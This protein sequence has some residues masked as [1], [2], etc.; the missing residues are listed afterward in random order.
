MDIKKN[1]WLKR[2]IA[3]YEICNSSWSLIEKIHLQ[4]NSITES[5]F[6][7]QKVGIY[8]KKN[9]TKPEALCSFRSSREAV[10]HI[11]VSRRMDALALQIPPHVSLSSLSKAVKLCKLLLLEA[12]Q[13][14]GWEEA[15]LGVL[16]VEFS[17]SVVSPGDVL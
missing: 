7:S 12:F 4:R 6:E 17:V 3:Y 14:R 5:N 15:S 13:L 16:F 8:Q 2:V 9:H 11:G 10:W 1:S